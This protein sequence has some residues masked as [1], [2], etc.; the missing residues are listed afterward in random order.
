MKEIG[1]NF[2]FVEQFHVNQPTL[3]HVVKYTRHEELKKDICDDLLNYADKQ[4]H[5]TNVK[6]TM[7]EWNITSPEI[8]ILKKSIIDDLKD[9]PLELIWGPP[10]EF[11]VVNIWGNVYRNG[12]ET[13]FHEHQPQDLTMVYFLKC[14]EGDAPLIFDGSDEYVPPVE[15]VMA[16]FPAYIKHGVPKHTSENI[17]ITLAADINRVGEKFLSSRKGIPSSVEHTPKVHVNTRGSTPTNSREY[18]HHY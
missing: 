7:T 4:G 9:F 3:I 12:E 17:R 18:D 16:I 15:G 6:A 1:S 14:G 2:K 10:G 5:L 11:D 8:E 13:I